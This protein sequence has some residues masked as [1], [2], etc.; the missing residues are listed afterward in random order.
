MSN[1][2]L[3]A[4][5]PDLTL[6]APRSALTPLG[7]YGAIAARMV[8]K[9]RAELIGKSGEYLYNCPLDRVFFRFTGIDAEEFQRF[10]ATGAG[11]DE[12]ARW[13][14]RNSK[15]QDLSR[16]R[17]W[18]Q[19]FRFSPILLMLGIDDWAHNRRNR[20]ARARAGENSRAT[21][22]ENSERQGVGS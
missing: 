8:D 5:A 21:G 4:L 19:R 3:L 15:V 7:A 20:V 16:V 12:V 9:C 10:V 2:K 18:S 11:D 6:Q 22:G 14:E 13:I 17:S 1:P